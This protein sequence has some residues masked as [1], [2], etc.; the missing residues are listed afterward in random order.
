M[1]KKK[2]AKY[3][4][5]TEVL[6]NPKALYDKVTWGDLLTTNEKAFLRQVLED[7]SYSDG[8]GL[9]IAI[10]A[11]ALSHPATRENI[12]LVET[13]LDEHF[14]YGVFVETALKALCYD[15]Y[16]NLSK[17]YLPLLRSILLRREFDAGLFSHAAKA[18]GMY[19]SNNNDK[20]TFHFIYDLFQQALS[21]YHPKCEWEIKDKVHTL[22]EALR[23]A[24]IP[25]E[26]RN[27]LYVEMKKMRFPDD[28][29]NK[30]LLQYLK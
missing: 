12:S 11:F 19:L 1:K 15:Y 24:S 25:H 9:S 28:V 29:D 14:H 20:E 27:D 10:E 2:I 4:Q 3:M 22:Y 16:W 26:K 30:L 13:F 18:L 17:D 8:G 23:Y 6:T 7:K 5:E 21:E